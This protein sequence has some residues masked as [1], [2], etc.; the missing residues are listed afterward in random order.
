MYLAG[1][2]KMWFIR[3]IPRIVSKDTKFRY[4]AKYM[5]I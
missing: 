1:Y 2:E 4:I 3:L 5:L